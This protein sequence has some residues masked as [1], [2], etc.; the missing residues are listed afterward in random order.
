MLSIASCRQNAEV[1]HVE[2]SHTRQPPTPPRAIPMSEHASVPREILA[3]LNAICLGLPE[4]HEESA[5]TGVRW[6]IGKKNFAHAVMI[7]RGWPPAYAQAA[8]RDGPLPVL[9]F[10]L[11]LARVAAP[12][13]ARAP[14]FKPPW[15]ADIVASRSM[16]T[17]IGMSSPT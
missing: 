17:A 10:R 14:F 12:K 13:F 5:W 6:M 11:P 4:V 1:R 8:G 7:D 9:T 3:R 2:S 15:F 16:R